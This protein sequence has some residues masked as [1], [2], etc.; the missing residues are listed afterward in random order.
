VTL[1]L[2]DLTLEQHQFMD[3]QDQVHKD[4]DLFFCEQ[5]GKCP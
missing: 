3:F 2:G 5:Q 4:S 1:Q